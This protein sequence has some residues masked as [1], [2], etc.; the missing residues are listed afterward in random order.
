MA[1]AE[2]SAFFTTDPSSNLPLN[3]PSQETFS[4]EGVNS[5]GD[6]V[7]TVFVENGEP[8]V[9]VFQKLV[10]SVPNI[11]DSTSIAQEEPSSFSANSTFYGASQG[12]V[13]SGLVTIATD[14]QAVNKQNGTTSSYSRVVRPSHLPSVSS[15]TYSSTVQWPS[16]LDNPPTNHVTITENSG[17]TSR[18]DYQVVLSDDLMQWLSNSFETISESTGTGFTGFDSTTQIVDESKTAENLNDA[19]VADPT[20]YYYG[21]DSSANKGWH[22]LPSS[23]S[24]PNQ[25]ADSVLKSNSSNELEFSSL[26]K[27]E[28]TG[29]TISDSPVFS[30]FTT[31]GNGTINGTLTVSGAINGVDVSTLS[32]DFTNHLGETNAHGV[33]GSIVGTDSIQTLTNKELTSPSITDASLISIPSSTGVVFGDDSSKIG[34]FGAV[35]VEQQIGSDGLNSD[36]QTIVSTVTPTTYSTAITS[37]TNT[38]AWGFTSEDDF[39]SFVDTV[40]TSKNITHE[41]YTVLRNLGFLNISV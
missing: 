16:V 25:V 20:S 7:P 12:D 40:I 4:R 3:S 2:Y 28:I 10:A 6:T 19:L 37:G 23:I 26:N 24:L 8:T 35:P 31:T 9:E 5:E 21:Y 11:L 34:F 39:N 1:I 22:A 15:G 18:S 32:T 27:E 33:S 36:Q 29:L 13:K 30:G 38:N 41:V 17:V 14:D